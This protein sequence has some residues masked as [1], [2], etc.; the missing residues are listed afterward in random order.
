[1]RGILILC[2]LILTVGLLALGWHFLGPDLYGENFS[3]EVP[4]VETRL[5]IEKPEDFLGKTVQ[6]E[7]TVRRQCLSTGCYFF[8]LVGEKSLRIEMGDVV[9]K[10]PARESYKARVEGELGRYGDGFQFY[11]RAVQFTRS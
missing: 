2:G 9:N 1:M 3:T 10:L 11:G 4:S 8:F 7:G 5:L 6:I